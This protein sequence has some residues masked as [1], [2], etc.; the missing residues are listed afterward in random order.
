MRRYRRWFLAIAMGV[1]GVLGA[2]NYVVDPFWIHRGPWSSYW[3]PIALQLSSRVAKGEVA[4]R[5]PVDVAIVGDSRTL[6][7]VDP[8]HPALARVGRTYNFGMP[9]AT[10]GET[11]DL[12]A[13]LLQD[14]PHRPTL[15][16]WVLQPEFLVVD[17]RPQHHW[18]YAFSRLNR[19]QTAA[20]RWF[21]SVWSREATLRSLDLVKGR[22]TTQEAAFLGSPDRTDGDRIV[23]RKTFERECQVL[24]TLYLQETT[25][26]VGVEM[27][28]PVGRM[29]DACARRGVRLEVVIAPSHA[30]YWKCLD[31]IGWTDRVELGKRTLVKLAHAAESSPRGSEAHASKVRIWDFSGFAGRAAERIP[32]DDG[33]IHWHADPVHFTRSLGDAVVSRVMGEET[34]DGELGRELSTDNVEAHLAEWRSRLARYRSGE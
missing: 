31:E 22:W 11:A 9:A 34:T 23:N 30:I 3:R 32:V 7:G 10:V 6:R 24:R 14:N 5:D 2:V 13:V 26:P 20:V 29:F 28:Q 8:T 25:P 1:L 33:P 4:A 16:L 27:E 17:R 19:E 18:D 12:M 15:I 21:H